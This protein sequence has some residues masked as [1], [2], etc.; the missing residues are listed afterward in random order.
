MDLI[1]MPAALLSCLLLPLRGQESRQKQVGIGH[2]GRSQKN[3]PPATAHFESHAPRQAIWR[4]AM[5]I[6]TTEASQEEYPEAEITAT[7][8]TD[9]AASCHSKNIPEARR[10]NDFRFSESRACHRPPEK[11]IFQNNE[12][13]IGLPEISTTASD[14]PYSNPATTTDTLFL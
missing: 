5:R 12:A 2:R 4:D 3:M 11:E 7:A 1:P 6:R 9:R 10:E 14:S 13:A 8:A